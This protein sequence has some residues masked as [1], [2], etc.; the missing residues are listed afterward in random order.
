MVKHSVETNPEYTRNSEELIQR[1][2]VAV[3]DQG[4]QF[5]DLIQKN[6]ERLG[7]PTDVIPFDTPV[8]EI[9]SNYSAVIISGS[10]ASSQEE[11]APMPDKRLWGKDIP[12]LGICYGM[13]AMV[14]GQGGV[15]E[16]GQIRQDGRIK[17]NVTNTHPLFR[18]TKETQTALFT[19]G[20]F[21]TKIPESFTVIG[22]HDVE[23]SDNVGNIETTKVIS[24]IEDGNHV[25]VQ[26][27]PEVFDDTPEGYQLF[28]NFFTKIANLKPS[29][30]L[31]E[32][33][34]EQQ[35][36]S[37]RANIREKVG[38]KEV[39]AFVSGGVDSSV[40]TALAT[41]EIDNDKLHAYYIDNG[42]MRD[43]D[44]LVIDLLEHLGVHVTKIN[45][46][47]QFMNTTLNDN[48][49]S[50]PLKDVIDPQEKRKII[51]KT[52]IDVQNQ[53]VEQ[54]G[55][56][57][58]MLLQGTNAADRIESGNSKGGSETAVIKTHHNQVKEV[59]DL[60]ERGLLIE[61]LD[62]LFKDEIR[63]I[64]R[65]L[66]LPTEVVDRHPF[67]GPGLAIRILG[68]RG[69]E[70][71]DIRLDKQIAKY[72]DS[73]QKLWG[74]N[75]QSL[76]LPVRNVGVGGDERSH[77]SPVA[78]FSE[79]ANWDQLSNVAIDLPANFRDQINRV[80]VGLGPNQP[81]NMSVTETGLGQAECT[82][83]RHADRIVFEEMRTFGIIDTIKQ[84]PVILLPLN[85]AKQPGA[86][87]IVL[88]PVTTSTFMTAQAMLPGRDLPQDFVYRCSERIL[89]EVNGISQVFLDLTNKPPGTTEWE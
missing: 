33:K 10:P 7:Y 86:R 35:I 68:S 37:I 67:P 1:N 89:G 53:I 77:V 8:D 19:H 42:F 13:H 32:L 62:E 14:T 25:A 46:T 73:Y 75:T 79:F 31:Q 47:E 15:V 57:E 87:S 6:A 28:K 80:I 17:T 83:L 78:I 38:N 43:E 9:T 85:F 24:A 30:E 71:I 23:Y 21:V 55:L 4:G 40:A 49:D 44:E 36:D 69:E 60:K 2:R 70:M 27:H 22:S 18:D 5:V 58:A 54:L 34:T 12:I 72:V 29:P 26:F 41:T 3:L 48:P 50:L 16:R 51:G 76:V 59:Q 81:N 63:T 56:T 84:C 39:I 45:A 66:G 52:F 20:N 88:R 11:K 61:P 74:T 82:Q 65:H 64:G